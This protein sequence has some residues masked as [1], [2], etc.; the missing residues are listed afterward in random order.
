VVAPSPSPALFAAW[1][2]KYLSGLATRSNVIRICVVVMALALFIM[3]KKFH[4][5]SGQLSAISQRRPHATP[6]NHRA[7][8]TTMAD[9]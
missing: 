3:I 4:G 6:P 9:R 7:P 1:Y 8:P 5:S 2:H